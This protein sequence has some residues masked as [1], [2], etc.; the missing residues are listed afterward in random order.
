MIKTGRH[1]RYWLENHVLSEYQK[2]KVGAR[3]RQQRRLLSLR[4]DLKQYQF[5]CQQTLLM[6]DYRNRQKS[7]HPYYHRNR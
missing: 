1:Y 3:D 7:L 5:L 2:P 4:R 6:H